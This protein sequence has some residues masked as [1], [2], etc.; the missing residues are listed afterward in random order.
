MT[1]HMSKILI[2]GDGPAGLSAALLL[3]KKGEEAHV[4][5]KNTTKMH[6][7]YLY[8]YPGIKQLDGTE[9]IETAREQC[10]YFGAEFHDTKIT[11]FERDGEGRDGG[12]F[13]I[14]DE[15]G[16]RY[17]GDYLVIATGHF[18]RK[19]P[20]ELSIEADDS[21]RILIDDHARTNVDG[22]YAAGVV[23]RTHKIQVAVSVGQG[24]AAALNIVDREQDGMPH[25]FDTRAN[26]HLQESS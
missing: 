7:A 23:T 9:F 24:T 15:D 3:A 14:V 21:G 4:F 13:A 17:E 18:M 8:N 26:A 20:S 25:D 19:H 5:G 6:Q 11:S 2:V 22:V 16:H 1:S 10:R 12:G